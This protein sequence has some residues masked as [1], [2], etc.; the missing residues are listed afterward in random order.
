MFKLLIPLYRLN[1]GARVN[2]I[3]LTGVLGENVGGLEFLPGYVQVTRDTTP[4][5]TGRLRTTDG[6]LDTNRQDTIFVV[7]G[8]LFDKRVHEFRFSLR[9]DTTRFRF[10]DTVSAGTLA[11]NDWSSK[12]G[13][14]ISDDS[15]FVR[16]DNNVAI[17]TQ[18]SLAIG[19]VVERKTDS[20]FSATLQIPGFGINFASCLGKTIALQSYRN[21]SKNSGKRHCF[22]SYQI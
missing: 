19:I 2:S 11:A 15:V 14:Y 3:E 6:I 17:T 22:N 18:D 4:E 9:A 12:R 13:P 20:A 21:R 1:G 8:N 16:F 5:Y 10:I 7:A